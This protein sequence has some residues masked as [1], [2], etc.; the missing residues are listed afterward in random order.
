[1][2]TTHP[3]TSWPLH[4]KLFTPEAVKGWTAACHNS[5][6]LPPGFTCCVEL[7]GVDGKSGQVGNGRVGPID[8]TDRMGLVDYC[9]PIISFLLEP[10][11]TE[12]LAKHLAVL[13]T[14]QPQQCTICGSDLDFH[15]IVSTC[16]L[17][18]ICARQQPLSYRMPSH[19]R[20]VL[21]RIALLIRIYSVSQMLSLLHRMGPPNHP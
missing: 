12:H 20:Y 9:D 21:H 2:L 6:P 3:Y 18:L 7:E 8:V 1:M 17:S 15:N 5:T 19:W 4:V 10:F 14:G 13:S 16:Q 11:T